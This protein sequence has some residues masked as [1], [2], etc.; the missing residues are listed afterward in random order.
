MLVV[1]KDIEKIAVIK[2]EIEADLIRDIS[3]L[4][5]IAG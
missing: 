3:W 5:M 4:S 2:D 1:I